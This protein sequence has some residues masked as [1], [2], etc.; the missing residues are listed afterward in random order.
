[1]DRNLIF[2]LALAADWETAE[3]AGTYAVSTLGRTLEEVGFIHCS[4]PEQVEDTARAFY[5]DRDDVLVL[6]IDPSLLDV[7]VR[8]ENGFPH[9]YGPIPVSAVTDVVPW[10]DFSL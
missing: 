3:G 7:E 9:V 4:Y 1:M 8:V 10:S 5:A 2:H 6:S